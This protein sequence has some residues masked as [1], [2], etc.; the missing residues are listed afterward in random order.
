MYKFSFVFPLFGFHVLWQQYMLQMSMLPYAWP[1]F[2]YAAIFRLI[3]HWLEINW[4][5][6]SEALGQHT[7]RLSSLCCYWIHQVFVNSVQETHMSGS[8]LLNEISPPVLAAKGEFDC[9]G[10]EAVIGHVHSKRLWKLVIPRH[11][12]KMPNP[13]WTN[14]LFCVRFNRML[15][16]DCSL[17]HLLPGMRVT[18]M[19]MSQMVLA[20][21]LSAL[22]P[23]MQMKRRAQH[24]INAENNKHTW[25]MQSVNPA[26]FRQVSFHFH[27]VLRS[28]L[29]WYSMA[30]K[31]ALCYEWILDFILSL[32]SVV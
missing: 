12:S 29:C 22:T 28:G 2:N 6:L 8:V 21:A 30:T 27:C 17:V 18:V 1:A 32:N 5:I 4:V 3:E 14:V 19:E 9:T 20:M 10:F 13:Y 31:C 15:M 7:V 24:W 25:M 23:W 11:G 16:G 26:V